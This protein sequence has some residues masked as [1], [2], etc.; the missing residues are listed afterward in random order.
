LVESGLGSDVGLSG[1]SGW[2]WALSHHQYSLYRDGFQPR[3]RELG[4]ISQ[5]RDAWLV[6]LVDLSGGRCPFP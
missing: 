2:D 6:L 4:L 1:L 3:G 5:H